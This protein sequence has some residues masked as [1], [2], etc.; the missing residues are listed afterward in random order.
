MFG[1]FVLPPL[2]VAPRSRPGLPACPPAFPAIERLVSQLVGKRD[3]DA[4]TE[5]QVNDREDLRRRC[6]RAQVTVPG[7][8]SVMT[9]KYSASTMLQPSTVAQR[10]VPLAS[11]EMAA[12]T[13][14]RNS[15]SRQL[16]P[17]ARTN[18]NS[19][20]R[21][22]LIPGPVCGRRAW[23]CAR[24]IR[25]PHS[26]RCVKRRGCH[27]PTRRHTRRGATAPLTLQ[28][29]GCVCRSASQAD[30]SLCSIRSCAWP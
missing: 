18:R 14:A 6:G 12:M 11:R 23:V 24:N 7:G 2:S 1:I 20:S 16:R 10:I 13:M 17:N 8:G 19:N 9:L 30:R 4:E 3:N 29:P 28:F 15:G 22:V 27:L 21:S 5:E 25:A 26:L